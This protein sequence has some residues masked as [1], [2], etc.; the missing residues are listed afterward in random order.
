MLDRDGSGSGLFVMES[1]QVPYFAFE[2][3]YTDSCCYLIDCRSIVS[4]EKRLT[5]LLRFWDVY[6]Q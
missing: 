4:L 1:V 6:F 3:L 5:E 2:I